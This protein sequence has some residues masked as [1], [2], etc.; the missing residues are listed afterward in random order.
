MSVEKTEASN[1]T[2]SVDDA[3]DSDEDSFGEEDSFSIASD[4]E[5]DA[6]TPVTPAVVRVTLQLGQSVLAKWGRRQ[7]YESQIC[8]I[9][10]EHNSD[11]C[12]ITVYCPISFKK[13]SDLRVS[14]VRPIDLD[15]KPGVIT[16]GSLINQVFF[17][18]GDEDVTES[19]WKV[20]NVDHKK[21]TFMCV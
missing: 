14:D 20:R 5:P 1:K 15:D 7:W 12:R 4:E 9:I 13:K 6:P 10:N 18:P 21:N 11:A 2:E 16:R 17:Y 8:D 19:T 3:V